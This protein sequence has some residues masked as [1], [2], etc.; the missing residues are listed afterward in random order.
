MNRNSTEQIK[1]SQSDDY[2]LGL[3]NDLVRYMLDGKGI[4]VVSA[5]AFGLYALVAC[6][7]FARLVL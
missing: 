2:G 6:I 5:C 4:L 1:T 7:A 3:M